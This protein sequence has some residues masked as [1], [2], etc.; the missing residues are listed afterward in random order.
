M[1]AVYTGGV[2]RCT[3]GYKCNKSDKKLLYLD[4]PLMKILERNELQLYLE[5]YGKLVKVTKCVPS[6]SFQMTF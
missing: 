4:F 2:P 5:K 3:T 6:I 1:A